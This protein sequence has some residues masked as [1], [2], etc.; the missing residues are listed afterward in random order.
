MYCLILTIIMFLAF[1][2]TCSG[3]QTT[4]SSSIAGSV[5]YPTSLP[6]PNGCVNATLPTS[7]V[8]FSTVGTTLSHLPGTPTNYSLGN[9]LLNISSGQS[10]QFKPFVH[11]SPLCLP[12]HNFPAPG[13]SCIH[14]G[15]PNFYPPSP[16]PYPLETVSEVALP[17]WMTRERSHTNGAEVH[18][19]KGMN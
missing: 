7:P 19:Y 12:A 16:H 13:N 2:A 10:S 5:T 3:M 18:L 6:L 1:Q 17:I 15:H 4:P 14:H 8:S 11:P 9:G